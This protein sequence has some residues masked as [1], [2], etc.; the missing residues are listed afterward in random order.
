MVSKLSTIIK[1]SV[2]WMKLHIH[3]WY[4]REQSE[5]SRCGY[6]LKKHCCKSWF[7][8]RNSFFSGILYLLYIKRNKYFRKVSQCDVWELRTGTGRS[9]HQ[10]NYK[11]WRWQWLKAMQCHVNQWNSKVE[12][13]YK[14]QERNMGHENFVW[15]EITGNWMALSSMAT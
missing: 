5:V 3:I 6:L 7:T 11:A 13:K 10:R 12:A 4:G 9:Q 8:C 1:C 14:L 15:N 2:D